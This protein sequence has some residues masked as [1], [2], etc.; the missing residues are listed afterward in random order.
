MATF[1]K[2]NPFDGLAFVKHVKSIGR[3]YRK[4]AIELVSIS[5]NFAQ[6]QE[7]TSRSDGD[8]RRYLSQIHAYLEPC[9]YVF[10]RVLK[11][12][13]DALY[14]A[15]E[16]QKKTSKDADEKFKEAIDA[17]SVY[18]AKYHCRK[19]VAQKMEKAEEGDKT[20]SKVLNRLKETF[21]VR[22]VCPFALSSY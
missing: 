2:S 10:E 3:S 17:L 6:V 21:R 8:L 13:D 18:E 14:S 11:V 7:Q 22:G 16:A 15:T 1:A 4:Q 9:S 12:V 5:R 19:I 20:S